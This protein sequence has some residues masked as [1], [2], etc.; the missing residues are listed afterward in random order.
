MNL[1]CQS[2]GSRAHKW[3]RSPTST[4][5]HG[6]NEQV[7][8]RIG[9]MC[10]C[11]RW[12]HSLAVDMAKLRRAEIARSDPSSKMKLLTENKLSY[13]GIVGSADNT[14]IGKVFLLIGGTGGALWIEA[15]DESVRNLS[16][17]LLRRL[18][19]EYKF[20]FISNQLQKEVWDI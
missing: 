11:T 15:C 12:Q 13:Y 2:S 4:F 20:A 6:R 8:R 10:S 18:S 9:Q 19:G 5:L 3:I 1:G 7:D 16:T 14:I 17:N